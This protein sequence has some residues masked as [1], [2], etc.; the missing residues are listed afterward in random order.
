MGRW[1]WWR[2]RHHLEVM[3]W[4]YPG[5]FARLDP[6]DPLCPR[7]LVGRGRRV[8]A[9]HRV[10]RL[11]FDRRLVPRSLVFPGL[12]IWLEAKGENRPL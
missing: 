1:V 6:P 2:R 10:D 8:S 4:W 12:L 7:V 9:D 11:E 3:L 5:P